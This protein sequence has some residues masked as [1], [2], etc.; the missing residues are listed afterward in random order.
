M[1]IVKTVHPDGITPSSPG[2]ET[3]RS[4]R[5]ESLSFAK[6]I[7][8][9]KINNKLTNDNISFFIFHVFGRNLLYYWI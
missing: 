9:L 4:N 2:R 1:A 6:H 7:A 5:E 8:V 3:G